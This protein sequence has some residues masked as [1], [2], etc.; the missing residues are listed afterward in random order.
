VADSTVRFWS[1][2][3]I[4][5]ECW[6]WTGAK[7]PN[8]YG[9]FYVSPGIVALAHRWAYESMVAQVPVGLVI[10]HVCRN[11]ACVNPD[12][13]D[14]V[15]QA[16]N[17]RRGFAGY[18]TGAL[19]AAKTHCP[20]GHPYTAENTLTDKRGCRSC[21]E[22]SRFRCREAQRRRRAEARLARG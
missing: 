21:R 11:R 3:A 16:I 18:V 5:G 2:V 20:E 4:A 13:M 12:H 1:K 19:N 8:G 22:C 9:R 7:M 15:P 6:T 14:V 10:D 17:V